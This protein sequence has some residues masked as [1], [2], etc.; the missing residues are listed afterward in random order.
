M[1]KSAKKLVCVMMAVVMI[2]AMGVTTFAAGSPTANGVVTP[3]SGKDNAGKTFDFSMSAYNQNGK[4]AVDYIKSEE[5]LRSI[6]GGSYKKGMQVI[7]VRSV[8]LGENVT[9]PVTLRFNVPGAKDNANVAVM[10]YVNGKWIVLKSNV[11]GANSVDVTFENAEQLELVAFAVD[12][13]TANGATGT[14]SPKT[15]ETTPIT[16]MAF[17]AVVLL[18]GGSYCLR[19]R[20]VR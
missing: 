4:S 10:A 7:D 12:A 13:S 2:L 9:Y 15:G 11:V 18:I 5:G 8:S 3:V 6:L 20:E 1:R 14:V 19:K 17:A 16:A